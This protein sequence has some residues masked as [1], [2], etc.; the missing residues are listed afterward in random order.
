MKRLALT[1]AL[2]AALCAAAGAQTQGTQTQGTQTQGEV[3]EEKRRD[4]VR[5]LE[6]TRAADLG[7]Q[8][9]QQ[10]TGSLRESFAML[11]AESRDKIFKVFQEEMSKEFSK[12]KMIELVVPIYD[13]HLSAEDV[14]GL[15]A[16]YETPLG[17]RTI[18]VM[19]AIAR[20]AYEVGASRG[21]EAGLRAMARIANEGLLNTPEQ[22]PPPK[23]K[24]RPR[25]GRA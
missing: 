10:M 13:R 25:R 8:I 4:I 14:K 7:T 24:P 1:L 2:L 15:I 22:P 17:R 19:P 11:P 16:F 5:L 3:S 23:P 12:E 21:R 6:L 20:E 18:E 9:I